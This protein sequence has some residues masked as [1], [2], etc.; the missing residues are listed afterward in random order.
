MTN[1]IFEDNDFYKQEELER[2]F[3]EVDKNSFRTCFRVDYARIIHSPSF[4]RLQ[5]KTQLF[6]YFE[7]DFFRNRLTHSLEVA[8][9]AKSIGLKFN[10]FLFEE[11]K[12]NF[13]ID[14]DLL[15]LAGLAHDLGHPPFG[16]IGEKAL[17]EQMLE[18]GGFEGNAQTLRILSKIEK[19]RIVNKEFICGIDGNGND[20]RVGLNLTHRSLASVLKYDKIIPIKNDD[21]EIKKGYYDSEKELVHAIKDKLGIK[22]NKELKSIEC[23]IMDIADDIAYS[24]YDLE[25]SFQAKF[26]SPFIITSSIIDNNFIAK[27]RKK[28]NKKL[29]KK[30]SS[31][32]IKDTIYEVFEKLFNEQ[33]VNSSNIIKENR[34]YI[35]KFMPYKTSHEIVERGY[36]RTELTSHLV[37]EFVS[38]VDL[39]LDEKN[40]VLSKIKIDPETRL[41]IEI[42]KN[43]TYISQIE[44]P[45]LKITEVRG[46]EIVKEIFTQLS[47]KDGFKLLPSDYRELYDKVKGKKNKNRIICDFIAGMTDRYAIEFYGRLKSEDP[48][49]IF[50][51]F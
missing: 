19:K 40:P 21:P 11:G 4:R 18:Y 38:A 35:N 13:K 42:L 2:K 9:I 51:P 50:K 16:H 17:H 39:E 12:A 41:R 25:D 32:V 49:T 22:R 5:G 10:Q 1:N 48:Q 14:L 27:L 33:D 28:V 6:P 23:D 3:N 43:Y 26:L 31:K 15:E 44:S 46:K 37:N 47:Q 34:P 30:Y 8:Q 45:K 7:S 24:T 36:L 20:K 29:N